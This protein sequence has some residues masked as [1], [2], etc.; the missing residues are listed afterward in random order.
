[1]SKALTFKKTCGKCGGNGIYKGWFTGVCSQC[2]GDGFT[3]GLTKAAKAMATEFAIAGL[4]DL[5]VVGHKADETLARVIAI[6]PN[7]VPATCSCIDLCGCSYENEFETLVAEASKGGKRYFERRRRASMS[8]K[9][10]SLWLEDEDTDG[11]FVDTDEEAEAQ[12]EQMLPNGGF[13]ESSLF[14]DGHPVGC[15]CY[16]CDMGV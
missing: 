16:A 4:G 1:M 3:A 5:I 9:A 10:V 8:S 2:G 13:F 14:A 15:S 6:K 12:R 11:E 7:A